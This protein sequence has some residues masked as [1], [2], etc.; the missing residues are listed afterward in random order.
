MAL[1]YLAAVDMG[2]TKAEGVVF[3]EDGAVVCRVVE[4]GGAP[5]DNGVDYS[6]NNLCKCVDAL[7]A[8][9]ALLAPFFATLMMSYIP[10]CVFYLR[11][12]LCPT[13]GATRCVYSFFSGNLLTAFEYNQFIFILIFYLFFVLV[14]WNASV[15]FDNAKIGKACKAV[16][17]PIAICSL[18]VLFAIFGIFR[19]FV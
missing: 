18:A 17:H 3:T 4:K 7:I 10:T 12:F 5:F 8:A 14:L 6:I 15:F 11:G 13:C 1:R 19:N 16:T 9:L 2:G